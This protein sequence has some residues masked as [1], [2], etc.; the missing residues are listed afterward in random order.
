[1]RRVSGNLTG[2]SIQ[3]IGHQPTLSEDAK[4]FIEEKFKATGD[5]VDERSLLASMNSGSSYPEWKA[6]QEALKKEKK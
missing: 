1:M 2:G 3:A 4:L 5:K 6:A